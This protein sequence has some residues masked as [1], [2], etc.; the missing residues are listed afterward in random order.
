MKTGD[1]STFAKTDWGTFPTTAQEEEKVQAKHGGLI[2]QRLKWLVFVRQG[3]RKDG[4]MPRGASEVYE[5]RRRGC[6]RKR[7]DKLGS[8]PLRCILRGATCHLCCRCWDQGGSRSE[9]EEGNRKGP[10]WKEAGE[11]PR[12]RDCFQ[13]RISN[14]SCLGE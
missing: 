8:Q 7:E 14:L 4:A 10:W 11:A 1:K 6:Q 5:R 2:E 9:G 3:T 13:P 12:N